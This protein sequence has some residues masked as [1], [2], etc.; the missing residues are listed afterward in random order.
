M[1]HSLITPIMPPDFR[2]DILRGLCRHAMLFLII[3]RLALAFR[4]FYTIAVHTTTIAQPVEI[5]ASRAATN[6][7]TKLLAV[8]A[9]VI[10]PLVLANADRKLMYRLHELRLLDLQTKKKTLLA[11]SV[12]RTPYPRRNHLIRIASGE[13]SL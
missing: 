4:E 9:V 10:M 11:N 7:T 12:R 13:A 1:A 5:L 8:R 3:T 6:G 2:R